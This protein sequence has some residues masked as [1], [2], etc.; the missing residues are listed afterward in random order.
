[1]ELGSV[2][3]QSSL[4]I[5]LDKIAEVQKDVA[6]I[7][8]IIGEIEHLHRQVL[9]SVSVEEATR[10]GR[11]IDQ[12]L[13]RTS[14]MTQTVR[15]TLKTLSEETDDLKA[16][17]EASPGE[18]RVRSTQQ[19]RWAKKFMATMNRFQAMQTTYQ[20]K[21]RQQLERQYL[22]VKPSATRE[23]LDQLTLSATDPTSALSQQVNP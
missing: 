16:R 21:Y 22:I 23:E 17:G 12:I 3:P 5:F 4:D 10:L 8:K 6:K 20:A 9:S 14:S 2:P 13:T 11:L 1:M 18:I 15:R 19:A 7:N